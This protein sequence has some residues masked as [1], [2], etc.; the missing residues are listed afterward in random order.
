MV[1]CSGPRIVKGWV[2]MGEVQVG[3]SGSRAS[4]VNVRWLHLKEI[5]RK[6][7]VTC[8]QVTFRKWYRKFCPILYQEKLSS[9]VN[10]QEKYRCLPLAG[11]LP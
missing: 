8:M 7:Q 2:R 5:S 9:G 10:F 6:T 1:G 3:C 11:L 4:K